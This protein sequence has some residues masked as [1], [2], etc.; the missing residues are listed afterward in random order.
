MLPSRRN[1]RNRRVRCGTTGAGA[2]REPLDPTPSTEPRKKNDQTVVRLWPTPP[3]K[4]EMPAPE[5]VPKATQA[6]RSAGTRPSARGSDSDPAADAPGETWSIGPRRA[7]EV[8]AAIEAWFP[9]HRRDLPWRRRRSAYG[10]LVSEF[11][12]QQTQVSRIAERYPRFLR[13]FPSIRRLAAAPLEAVLA[14][15]QGLGY[16]RRARMLHAAAAEIVA[17]HGGRVPRD[18]AVL[19]R[20]P[21][22]GRYTAGAIA[23]IAYGERAAIV[24]GNVV[25]VLLRLEGRPLASDD[26][27]ALKWAWRTSAALVA[28]AADPAILNEGLMELGATVCTPMAPRCGDCPLRSGCRGL[29][30]GDPASIPKP[31]RPPPRRRIDHHV[32]LL[33]REGRVLLSKRPPEG[34]WAGLWGPPGIDAAPRRG[35]QAIADLLGVPASLVEAIGGFRHLTS[36]REVQVHLHRLQDALAATPPAG[37]RW[38]DEAMLASLPLG[39][40]Q[41]RAIALAREE[42]LRRSRSAA[43][44]TPPRGRPAAA[45]PRPRRKS[46]DS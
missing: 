37:C 22:I 19:E 9:R 44:A 17:R 27:D 26:G 31:K 32:V 35:R 46:R 40:L 23:S 15:W 36:H 21:G 5:T 7:A 45:S 14:E 2:R 12:L 3:E 1:D 34:L 38:A 41:R 20:L 6:P 24:D 25:R 28:A 33:E 16:Y 8:A 13:R 42:T 30:G 11:L 43:A 39:S 4:P 18:P 10:T 29:A